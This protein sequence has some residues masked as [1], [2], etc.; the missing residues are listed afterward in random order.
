MRKCLFFLI[1]VSILVWSFLPIKPVHADTGPK[2]GMSFTFTQE[3]PGDP[4]TI[5][6]GE[7]FE[8]E[9]AD[10]QDAAPLMEVGPQHFSCQEI[11][12]SALGYGFSTY[13]QIEIVFSDGVTRRSNVFKTI[14]FNSS[15]KVT[16][17]Q[18]DLL[19]EPQ[20]GIFSFFD[21]F[22]GFSV[23]P[24]GT[25]AFCGICL[26]GVIVIIIIVFLLIRRA[27]KKK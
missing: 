16:I 4:V 12:C 19:V 22:S 6:S 7:L 25:L 1:I 24:G 21:I 9:Q 20:G 10:C 14:H 23:L 13:H 18:D 15:Y 27:S 11:T 2:P 26:A 5:V 3:L 17:R 8:C